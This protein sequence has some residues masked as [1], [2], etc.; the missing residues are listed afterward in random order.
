MIK[1]EK[2]L[3]NSVVSFKA[4]K[5]HDKTSEVMVD[6]PN[7]DSVELS[8]KSNKN[9]HTV[10]KW[11]IGGTTMLVAG[12]IAIRFHNKKIIKSANKDSNELKQK[13]DAELKKELE[14]IKQEGEKKAKAIK[15]EYASKNKKIQESA[16]KTLEQAEEAKK[17]AEIMRDISEKTTKEIEIKI[18]QTKEHI[19]QIEADFEKMKKE[20]ERISEKLND[21]WKK[22]QE[23]DKASWEKFYRDLDE[24]FKKYA[25]AFQDVSTISKIKIKAQSALEVLKKYGKDSQ[26][27]PFEEIVNLSSLDSLSNENLKKAHW[28]LFKKYGPLLNTG[29]DAEKAN[30]TKVMQEI[31]P[32]CSDLKAYLNFK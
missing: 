12:I 9:K 4:K 5:N 30:A 7:K 3:L 2:S 24:M 25:N 19:K 13:A 8:T 32:A 15:E 11:I 18:V 23:S 17:Q 6:Q 14:R 21:A 27:K 28:K 22:F 31:N 29:S 1:V 16:K 26:G 20:S 10:L